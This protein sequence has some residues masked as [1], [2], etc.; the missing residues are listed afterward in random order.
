MRRIG[1]IAAFFGAADVFSNWHP[2]CFTYHEV[3]FNSVEQFMMYAKALL[4]DD[5]ATAAAILASAS[6]REQK[7]L[8]RLVRGFDDAR[9]VQVRE[10]IMFVGCREKFRQNEAFLT[11]LRATGTSI[12]VEASPYDRIWGVGLGE[13]DPRIADPSAWQG[14][15]L[16]GKALMRVRDLLA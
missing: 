14:L 6:P 9:W 11:A 8:G 2:C 3:A 15:N 4:F 1:N 12:L 7:R 13:H 16:L 5:H 10:S